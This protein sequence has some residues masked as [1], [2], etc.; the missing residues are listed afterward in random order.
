MTDFSLMDLVASSILFTLM[1]IG[2]GYTHYHSSR[3]YK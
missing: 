2:L 3:W 1:V